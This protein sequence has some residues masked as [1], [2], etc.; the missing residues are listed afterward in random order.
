MGLCD[1]T[2]ENKSQAI[3]KGGVWHSVT[4]KEG[5]LK[6]ATRS[7]RSKEIRYHRECCE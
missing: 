4:G 6:G 2:G 5:T 7:N 1:L 3:G